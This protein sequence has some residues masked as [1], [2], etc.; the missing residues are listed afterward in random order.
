[1]S[2]PEPNQVINDLQPPRNLMIR[3]LNLPGRE[4][5]WVVKRTCDILGSLIALVLML[6]ISLPIM[7]LIFIDDP[8]GCPIFRQHRCGR[9]GKIF[10][11]YK[12]RTMRADAVKLLDDLL[13]QN[14]MEGPAFKIKNDPRITRF[15]K[16]LRKTSLD[17]LPQFWNILKGD[18][19]L[20][21]PRPPLPREVKMYDEYQFQR[22]YITPGLTCF[23]QIAPHRNDISFDDWLEMDID[24]IIRRSFWLDVSILFKTV[25]AV[26]RLDSE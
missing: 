1:M 7:L 5:F 23:W 9:G 10:T 16:L 2:M 11:M 26:F 8:H 4:N 6:P 19:S 3:E 21:G 22:L 14:E 18:M 25:L 17:E 15:G 20:V 13:D 12:F 24:Y